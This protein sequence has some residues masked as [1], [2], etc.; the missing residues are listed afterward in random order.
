MSSILRQ[1]SIRP[2]CF[3]AASKSLDNYYQKVTTIKI[4]IYLRKIY[5]FNVIQYKTKQK[6]S[7]TR[8]NLDLIID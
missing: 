7:Q 4:K 6:R 3:Q 8:T 2:A 5:I 1:L